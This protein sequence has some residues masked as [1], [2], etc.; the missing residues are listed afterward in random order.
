MAR[1]RK[2]AGA[3]IAVADEKTMETLLQLLGAD[4]EAGCWDFQPVVSFGDSG[5]GWLWVSSLKKDEKTRHLP[6]V[7]RL[8]GMT[9]E[10]LC[11]YEVVLVREG[12]W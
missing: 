4:R 7:A 8:L 11:S 3:E 5:Y 1:Q 12:W 9:T 10:E 2:F 6:E